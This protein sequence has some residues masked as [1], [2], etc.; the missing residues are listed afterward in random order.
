MAETKLRAVIFDVDGT[1]GE[2]ERHGHRVAFNRAMEQRGLP[3]SWSDE[4]YRELVKTT[5]GVRRLT[6]YFTTYNGMSREEALP[7]AEELH[8]VKT[9]LF[10][11]VV[12]SAEVPPRPGS[13]RFI[14][15]LQESGI[16]TAVATT[17]TASWVHP[18]MDHLVRVGNLEPFETIV[19]GD[20]VENL[21]PAPDAFILCLDRLQL[22]PGD[23][24]IVEDSRN[25][26]RA[27]MAVGAAC[28]AV[29]GEYALTEELAGAD[30]A[31]DQFGEPG[32]PLE[33]LLNP[34]ALDVGPAL[35]PQVARQLHYRNRTG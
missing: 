11:E 14:K 32:A 25:G 16:R 13:V 1:L 10:T 5:G 6:H 19:T 31:V 9:R 34:W 27:S 21:K 20:L 3:D 35:T 12:T 22:D 28:L 2:T 15:L 30:L 26:V 29:R 33:V 24:V 4:M 23:V 7:L 18:L 17:G 8:R